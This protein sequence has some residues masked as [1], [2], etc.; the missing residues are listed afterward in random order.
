MSNGNSKSKFQGLMDAAGKGTK[1]KGKKAGRARKT[2]PAKSPAKQAERKTAKSKDPDFEQITAY[3]RKDT[4]QQTKIALL[5]E[6]K[7]QQ[8]SQLVETLLAKWLKGRG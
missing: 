6:G 8:F 7:D 1:P 3:I 2:A 4:H 5:Q